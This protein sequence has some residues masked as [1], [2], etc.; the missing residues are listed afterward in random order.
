MLWTGEQLA[1]KLLRVHDAAQGPSSAGEALQGLNSAVLQVFGVSE[2]SF[3]C[4]HVRH[5]RLQGVSLP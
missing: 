4:F 1:Q 2:V 3:L 5:T